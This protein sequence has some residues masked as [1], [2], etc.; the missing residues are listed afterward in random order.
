MKETVYVSH[1]QITHLVGD[2]CKDCEEA[3]KEFEKA[4]KSGEVA[5]MLASIKE[6]T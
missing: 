5:R 2:P 6:E 3:E 4:L 1:G